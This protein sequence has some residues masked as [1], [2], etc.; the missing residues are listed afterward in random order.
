MCVCVFAAQL[1]VP[2]GWSF[3]GI[4]A[5]QLF[6]ID[7]TCKK[8]QLCLDS[9][10]TTQTLCVRVCLRASVLTCVNGCV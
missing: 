2:L 5:R 6:A 1:L 10:R 8:N 3:A 7:I 4:A 9:Q